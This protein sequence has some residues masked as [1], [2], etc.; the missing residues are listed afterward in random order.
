MQLVT[1]MS[2]LGVGLYSWHVDC[3]SLSYDQAKQVG[4]RFYSLDELP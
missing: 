2:P 1:M 3:T 4:L